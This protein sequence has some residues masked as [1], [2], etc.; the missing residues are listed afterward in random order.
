MVIESIATIHNDAVLAGHDAA[1]D[2]VGSA[3]TN[4]V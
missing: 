2:L 1:V 4:I 3:Y